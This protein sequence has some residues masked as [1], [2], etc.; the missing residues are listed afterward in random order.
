MSIVTDI[1]NAVVF[2]LANHEFSQQF[3]SKML[4]L[5]SF[6]SAELEILRV[7]VV[8]RTLGIERATRASSKYAVTR[9]SSKYAVGVDIGIQKRIVGTPEET[10]SE[11]GA[12]VD[13]IADFLKETELQKFPEAQFHSLICDPLYVPEHL[14]QKRVFTSILSV[15]Y[16]LQS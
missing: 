9:A 5:P 6:E 8:P 15:N 7:S 13:E 1:A 12:L 3:E 14:A 10:V 4:V 2:E 11:M 16:I